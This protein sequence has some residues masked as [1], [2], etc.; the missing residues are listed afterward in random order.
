MMAATIASIPD[1]V[2]RGEDFLDDDGVTNTPQ[3]ITVKIRI[4]GKSVEID[5]TGSAPQ[6]AGSVNA[7]AAITESAVFYVFRCLLDEQVPATSGLMRSIRVIAPAGLIVNALPPAA[8]AGGN[9]E[10]SQRIVDT[11]LKA[12]A[13]ALPSRIPAASQGTM[14][15][16]SFGGR[17]PRRGGQPFAYYETIAGGTGGGPGHPGNSA[18]HSHMTNTLNTPIEVLE[19]VYPVRVHR[20]SVR[21]GSGG[22]GRFSGGEGVVREIEI[23]A[24]VQAGILSDRRKRPPY[25]LSGGA[26]GS[27]GKNEMVIEGRVSK[28]PSK[29]TFRAPA[30]ALIRIETPGGGG[31]GTA[32]RQRKSPSRKTKNPKA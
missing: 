16:L 26:P 30:G 22:R 17:D 14:N 19:H 27:P 3:R 6:C 4:R 25:G 1:G 12:L 23:L 24:D 31:W 32:Q 8:V 9:V 15:N 10:T 20:Y 2:Y 7:V 29:C 5:F 18:A 11:L 13:Q 28:L 21:K